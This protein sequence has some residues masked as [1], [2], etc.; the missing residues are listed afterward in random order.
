MILRICKGVL[1][2]AI[3]SLST[4]V[5][6]PPKDLIVPAA[7]S[8]FVGAATYKGTH[9]ML[10]KEHQGKS[11]MV[12]AASGA[13]FALSMEVAWPLVLILAATGGASSQLAIKYLPDNIKESIARTTGV[14]AG[15]LTLGFFAD[16]TPTVEDVPPPVVRPN[17]PG[18]VVTV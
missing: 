10:S 7:T 5:S 14:T 18:Q 13:V 12:S 16:K 11:L 3:N 4:L 17:G 15:F 2:L 6:R 9:V 8:V 1:D